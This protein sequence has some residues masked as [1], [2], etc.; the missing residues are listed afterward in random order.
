MDKTETE[1][2]IYSKLYNFYKFPMTMLTLIPLVIQLFVDIFSLT[3]FIGTIALFGAYY[4]YIDREE[5]LLLDKGV[6]EYGR[7]QL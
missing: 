5:R 2:T 7:L 4:L 6:K 1:Y 3:V